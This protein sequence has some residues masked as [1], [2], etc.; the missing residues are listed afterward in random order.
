MNAEAD[1]TGTDFFMCSSNS[2]T[3]FSCARRNLQPVQVEAS[4]VS[5]AVGKMYGTSPSQANTRLEWATRRAVSFRHFLLL[6]S[7]RSTP[8]RRSVAQGRLRLLTTDASRRIFES[9]S[10]RV[11]RFRLQV[12]G[13]VVMPEH[14]HLP[15]SYTHLDVYKRQAVLGFEYGLP[16][17]KRR[18][19]G[20]RI[21]GWPA[22]PS[23]LLRLYFSLFFPPIAVS[24]VPR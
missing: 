19:M 7:P 24:V 5:I 12:Y 3:Y 23:A 11:R 22:L 2:R 13:Y 14:V 18:A 16:R 4:S 15:V 17:A 6:P 21:M 1:S 9:A 20:S 10:E 8:S